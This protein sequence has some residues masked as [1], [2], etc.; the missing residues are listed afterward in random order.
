MAAI[1]RQS[2]SRRIDHQSRTLIDSQLDR[3]WDL[4]FQDDA[5]PGDFVSAVDLARKYAL[6]GADAIHLAV[7]RRLTQEFGTAGDRLVFQTADDELI[8]AARK[9][10]LTVD[11]PLTH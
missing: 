10:G 3:E 2:S 5:A 11:N 4:F 8:V 1:A 6:R 7:V 9:A